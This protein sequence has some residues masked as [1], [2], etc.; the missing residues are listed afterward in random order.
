[1]IPSP[2]RARIACAALLAALVA[3]VPAVE[4]TSTCYKNTANYVST[5]TAANISGSNPAC[6]GDP[7]YTRISILVEGI[8]PVSCSF[9][10]GTIVRCLNSTDSIFFSAIGGIHVFQTANGGVWGAVG[11][12]LCSYYSYNTTGAPC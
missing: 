12:G 11:G 4:A 2:R 5:L 9:S 6:P 7:G 10:T 8:S 1:M 3:L